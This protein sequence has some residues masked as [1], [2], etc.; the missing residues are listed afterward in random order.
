[1]R[2]CDLQAWDWRFPLHGPSG[3]AGETSESCGPGC[4]ESPFPIP[5]T[6]QAV[7]FSQA[8]NCSSLGD[9]QHVKTARERN[10]ALALKDVL[11]S[12][13][14]VVGCGVPKGAAR[15]IPQAGFCTVP[16]ALLLVLMH[17]L[18]NIPLKAPTP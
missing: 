14:G 4:Q 5:I 18:F 2:T 8:G 3:D 10:Q 7:S 15:T 1:M 11:V 12:V 17:Q 9:K 16:K 6:E 13:Q